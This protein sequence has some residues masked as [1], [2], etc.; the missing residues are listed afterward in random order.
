MSKRYKDI[1]DNYNEV[2]EFFVTDTE[3]V[4]N[5]IFG[6][7]KRYFYDTCS[8]IHHSNSKSYNHII[9][10]LNKQEAVIIITRTV[11]MELTSNNFKIDPIQIKFFKDIYKSE[12]P[13]LLIEEEIVFFILKY[14]LNITNG[15]ANK[16][17]GYAFHEVS[18]YKAAIYNIKE[19]FET[20]FIN[21]LSNK[22]TESKDL[23]NIFF[24]TARNNK[25][26]SDSLAEELIFIISIIL[27]KIPGGKYYLISDDLKIRSNLI[28]INSYTEK[29][30]NIK[31]PVQITSSRIIYE[32]HRKNIIKNKEEMIEI[33]IA[34]SRGNINTY[35]MGEDD[36]KLYKRTYT[37]E[38]LVNKII[39]EPSFCI[40]Y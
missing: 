3:K 20:N 15:D 25:Q 17:L 21:K 22:N 24:Q 8:I 31:A 28:S 33:L 10:Y 36:I 7:E 2:K 1:P 11:L 9:N 13:M 37:V 39:T 35:C 34:C 32:M 5:N 40:A 23:Y 29:H 18:R 14:A 19:N 38:E 30:H 26:E 16:L 4:I 6:R 12:I 27:T